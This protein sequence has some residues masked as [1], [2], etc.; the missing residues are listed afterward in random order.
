MGK[1]IFRVRFKDLSCTTASFMRVYGTDYVL[2]FQSRT[3]INALTLK[4]DRNKT[5]SSPGWTF[6]PRFSFY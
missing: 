6:C 2:I 5:Y 1:I 3:R 4:N